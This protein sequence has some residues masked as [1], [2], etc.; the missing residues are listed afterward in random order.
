M[1]SSHILLIFDRQFM[2]FKIC[3]ICTK[4]GGG[5]EPSRSAYTCLYR[6]YVCLTTFTFESIKNIERR[7]E[8]NKSDIGH[9]PQLGEGDVY[10]TQTV[11]LRSSLVQ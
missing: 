5:A 4:E 1:C 8:R 6:L 9:N 11:C 2:H 10:S 3:R 7:T